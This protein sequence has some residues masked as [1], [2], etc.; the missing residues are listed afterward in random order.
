MVANNKLRSLGPMI[1]YNLTSLEV[2]D[3]SDNPLLSISY[4]ALKDVPRLEELILN[5]CQITRLDGKVF[6]GMNC[7]SLVAF[8]KSFI[9]LQHFQT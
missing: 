3:L 8:L 6:H 5:G 7:M 2:L 1:F 9:F 4:E